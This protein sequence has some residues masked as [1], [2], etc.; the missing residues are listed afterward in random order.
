MSEE[1]KFERY[2]T[3]YGRE[4]EFVEHVSNNLSRKLSAPYFINMVQTGLVSE[5]FTRRL[6]KAIRVNKEVIESI[7]MCEIDVPPISPT[8]DQKYVNA[9]ASIRNRIKGSRVIDVIDKDIL[10]ARLAELEK[11]KEKE[12]PKLWE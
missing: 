4:S 6:L 10:D 12:A 9:I 8:S 11:L 1:R 3:A 5:R 2:N 7:L